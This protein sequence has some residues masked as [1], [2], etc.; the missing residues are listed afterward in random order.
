M[1]P[2]RLGELLNDEAAFRKYLRSMSSVRNMIALRDELRASASAADES[3]EIDDELAAVKSKLA[4]LKKQLAGKLQQQEAVMTKL[5]VS[6][7]VDALAEL[8]ADVEEETD[9]LAHDFLDGSID[10]KTFQKT[11]VER[12]QLFHLRSAKK[13][14]LMIKANRERRG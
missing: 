11:Y 12:R 4:A 5:Q 3:A 14:S 8:A 9:E 7:L 1:Q 13:E 10:A 2:A 6:N